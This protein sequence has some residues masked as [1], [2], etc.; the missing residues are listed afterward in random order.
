MMADR[1][2]HPDAPSDPSSSARPPAAP[3]GRRRLAWA[4]GAAVVG[5]GLFALYLGQSRTAPFNS[6]GAANVLQGRAMITGNPLL[7]GWWTSDVSFYGTELPEYALVTAVRGVAPDVVHLCGALTYT[8]TLLLALLLARGGRATAIDGPGPDKAGH[9]RWRRAV[10][11][12]GVMLAPGLLGGTEVFLENPDHAGT[13]VPVLLCLLLVDRPPL[14]D[15]TGARAAPWA[16]ALSRH[17][18][19]ARGTEPS[20]VVSHRAKRRRSLWPPAPNRDR[21]LPWITARSAKR[22][23]GPAAVCALLTLA[24]VG[25]ELT[26]VA[27]TGPLAAVCAL[28]LVSARQPGDSAHRFHPSP[29][30]APFDGALLVAA[31]LSVG[32]AK[33]ANLTI[34]ALGGFGLRPLGGVSLAPLRQVPANAGR[35]WQALILLFGANSPGTPHQAQTIRAHALLVTMADLHL[36]G[37]LVAG[38]GLAAGLAACLARRADRV[39]QVLVAAVLAVLAAAVFS[40]VLRSL[41]NAHEI[42]ILLPLGAALAGRTF[43]AA[44]RHPLARQRRPAAPGP[45]RLPGPSMTGRVNARDLPRSGRPP[46]RAAGGRRFAAVATAALGAWLALSLAELGYAAAWPSA[47]SA[48]RAVSAWLVAHHER[49][50]LSGYWQATVTTVTAGGQVTVAPITIPAAGPPGPSGP[51]PASAYRWE[52]SSAWYQPSESDA[53]FVIAV[54]SLGTPG[55]G[56]SPAQVQASFGPP[57]AEHQIGQYLIMLYRHNLLTRLTPTPF[58]GPS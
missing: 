58:P 10:V 38:L 21:S 30:T 5:C 35:L 17:G 22:W 45:G 50:G 54:T 19:V 23:L 36:V 31:F 18:A 32:L 16:T 46:G 37:L 51:R 56:L 27:V 2:A 57:S 12:A 24:Q 14:S 44:A 39:T 55:G 40:T 53:T 42:A 48:P 34:R 28:R 1:W 25:D 3:R 9:V 47:Q 20:G 15:R 13:A 41:S 4:L 8:L 43:P 52:S 6:D 33:L 49:A 7:R 11:A 26:L 29:L